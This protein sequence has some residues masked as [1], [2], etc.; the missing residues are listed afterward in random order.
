M[1]LRTVRMVVLSFGQDQVPV[2][3]A[4]FLVDDKGN[5]FHVY[6]QFF[7]QAMVKVRKAGCY[8]P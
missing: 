5:M 7:T 4:V 6:T 8:R 3:A 2:C 1:V